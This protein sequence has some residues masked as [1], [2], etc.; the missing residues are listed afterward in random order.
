MDDTIY[1]SPDDIEIVD[2][3]DYCAD[4]DGYSS[5][6]EE[7]FLLSFTYADKISISVEKEKGARQINFTYSPLIKDRVEEM[8]IFAKEQYMNLANIDKSREFLYVQLE[9]NK[10]FQSIDRM[11]NELFCDSSEIFY[12]PAGRS[13]I[14]LLTEQAINFDLRSMDYITSQCLKWYTFCL[15]DH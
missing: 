2:V 9:K 7:R 1:I 15:V 14:T 3:S 8:E 11:V 12:I 5:K 10:V 13:L 4:V 6:Q